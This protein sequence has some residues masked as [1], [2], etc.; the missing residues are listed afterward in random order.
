[1]FKGVENRMKNIR[2]GLIYYIRLIR[3][4]NR[5][6]MTPNANLQGFKNLLKYSIASVFVKPSEKNQHYCPVNVLLIANAECGKTRLLSEIWC[7]KVYKT[8]DFSPKLIKDS[9]IPKLVSKEIGFLVVPDLIQMLGH[10]KT[11]ISSTMGFLNA[12]VEEGVKDNDFYGLE[13]HLQE[14][15]NVGLI[16]A[17]TTNEFYQNVIK[18]NSIGFLHRILPISYDYAEE[19]I[20]Q[21]HNSIS[22][23]EMFEDISKVDL[24]KKINPVPIKI[25]KEFASDILLEVYR[26]RERLSE[27]II[28]SYKGSKTRNQKGIKFDIK[29]FRLHDRFRQLARA[30]CFLD[31]KGKRREVNADDIM[32]LKEM[33]K[34]INFPN[35]KKII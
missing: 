15:V 18:W 22:S 4:K 12:L 30:I 20:L 29:G 28:K 34:C 21:I 31:S 19:T 23:G 35:S 13:F 14:K 2:N 25:G 11:T 17:I 7:K 8:L 3:G 27:F 9:I 24:T 6:K 16:S 26:T 1:M 5:R 10:K 32:K 33:A